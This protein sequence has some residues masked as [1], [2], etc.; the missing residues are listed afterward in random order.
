MEIPENL[1]LVVAMILSIVSFSSTIIGLQFFNQNDTD[2]K[3][4]PITNLQSWKETHPTSFN[5]LIINMVVSIVVLLLS[6]VVLFFKF[7]S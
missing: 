6:F 4:S 5:F 2:L 3:N 7:R 1:I